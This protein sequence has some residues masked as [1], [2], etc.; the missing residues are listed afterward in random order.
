MCCCTNFR[1][2]NNTFTNSYYA[3]YK[4]NGTNYMYTHIWLILWLEGFFPKMWQ[5][6]KSIICS[7]VSASNTFCDSGCWTGLHKLKWLTSL[8]LF[9]P[10]HLT[11][12]SQFLLQILSTIVKSCFTCARS[13]CRLVWVKCRLELVQT[14]CKLSL[15]LAQS[16]WIYYECRDSLWCKIETE[17]KWTTWL[18]GIIKRKP[19]FIKND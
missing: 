10:H 6:K 7:L 11:Q 17:R 4:T 9:K 3:P 8:L 1:D 18:K 15:I 16:G 5:E 13:H 2:E 14:A 19:H 12:L